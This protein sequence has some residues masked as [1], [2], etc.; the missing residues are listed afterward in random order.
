MLDIILLGLSV[1]ISTWY[2]LKNRKFGKENSISA[3]AKHMKTKSQKFTTYV[4]IWIGLCFPLAFVADHWLTTI[5]AGLLTFDGLFTGYNPTHLKTKWQNRF[6]LIGVDGAI[7]LFIV[8]LF[9]I[10]WKIA[11][12]TFPLG[13][14]CIVLWAKKVK[15]HTFWIEIVLII[16]II[17]F[18]FLK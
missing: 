12:I 10:N 17:L 14:L 2:L 6:H 4:F 9:F 15:R 16:W 5:A 1:V 3:Y 18:L 8:G 7:G 11:L 13:I